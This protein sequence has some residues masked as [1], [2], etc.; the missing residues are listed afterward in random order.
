MEPFE[1]TSQAHQPA[2]SFQHCLETF[3]A[4]IWGS[5]E[6]AWQNEE[7]NPCHCNM[8]DQPMG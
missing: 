6:T 5:L 3:D 2:N 1:T 4:N 8:S 7:E